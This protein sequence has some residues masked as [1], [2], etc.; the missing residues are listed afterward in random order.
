MP[1]PELGSSVRFACLEFDGDENVRIVL[2]KASIKTQKIDA[3]VGKKKNEIVEEVKSEDLEL[4][5]KAKDGPDGTILETYV[6]KV[7]YTENVTKADGSVEAT[8]RI[9][10]ETRARMITVSDIENKKKVSYRIRVPELADVNETTPEGTESIKT[11]KF[12][13]ESQ[14]K[15][16]GKD[17]KI[18][19][20]IRA[21]RRRQRFTDLQFSKLDGTKVTYA[22]VAKLVGNGADARLPI[23]LLREGA[24]F[25]EYFSLILKPDTLVLTDPFDN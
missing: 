1:P 15:I 9:R 24:T 2:S 10:T 13:T 25:P 8:Q 23:V 18:V 20:T 7:P 14:S 4:E 16:I 6:V 11:M 5:V 3:V 17:E 21:V 12:K 22:E 19:K